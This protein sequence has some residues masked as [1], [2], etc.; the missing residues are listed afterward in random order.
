MLPTGINR[1]PSTAVRVRRCSVEDP[2]DHR[3]ALAYL[4]LYLAR[5]YNCV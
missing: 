3:S 5:T 4:V 1:A 2:I